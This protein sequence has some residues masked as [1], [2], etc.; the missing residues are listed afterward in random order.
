[1]NTEY[2]VCIYY[3]VYVKGSLILH[4]LT[5]INKPTS[6]S[7]THYPG[8]P[9]VSTIRRVCGR[10]GG[11]VHNAYIYCGVGALKIFVSI[12][13]LYNLE[14]TGQRIRAVW[15]CKLSKDRKMHILTYTHTHILH[16]HTCTRINIG[17]HNV[18]TFIMYS[19]GRRAAVRKKESLRWFESSRW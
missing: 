1:M 12:K 10:G 17:K 13:V 5:L 15:A 19:F 16:V 2:C 3:H 8:V 9:A 6:T 11:I 14:R 18:R 7:N 4:K